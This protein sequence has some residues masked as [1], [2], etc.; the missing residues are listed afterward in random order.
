MDSELIKLRLQ[1]IKEVLEKALK[2]KS[3]I[4][5]LILGKLYELLNR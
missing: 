5:K 3:L 2:T 4:K 1:L